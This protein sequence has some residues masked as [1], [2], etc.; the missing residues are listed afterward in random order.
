MIGNVLVSLARFNSL[1]ACAAC[2]DSLEPYS[3]AVQRGGR[4]GEQ[5][6]REISSAKKKEVWITLEGG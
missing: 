4:V 5:D 1:L 3:S 2:V 6:V